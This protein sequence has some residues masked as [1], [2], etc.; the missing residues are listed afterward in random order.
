MERTIVLQHSQTAQPDLN[1]ENNAAKPKRN[2]RFVRKKRIPNSKKQK[3]NENTSVYV[4]TFEQD[5][6]VK[7]AR[8]WNTVSVEN[9][10]SFNS[11][12]SCSN[13]ATEAA[14]YSECDL[15]VACLI[16]G[17]FADAQAKI[18]DLLLEGEEAPKFNVTLGT[19]DVTKEASGDKV[20]MEYPS[21][22][23]FEWYHKVPV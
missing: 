23:R 11:V 15:S 4:H 19:E 16:H 8:V 22:K 10:I 1:A 20:D 17:I 5:E 7:R 21:K 3:T 2:R 14:L 13:P 9:K 18:E 6:S 12:K